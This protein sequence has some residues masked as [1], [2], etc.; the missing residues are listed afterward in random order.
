MS[1]WS[2]PDDDSTRSA[3]VLEILSDAWPLLRETRVPSRAINHPAL[4]P[5]TAVGMLTF[6][7]RVTERMIRPTFEDVVV[8]TAAQDGG[9]ATMLHYL[10]QE[11][12]RREPLI[13]TYGGRRRAMPLLRYRSLAA[14]VP[15]SFLLTAAGPHAYYHRFTTDWHLDLE[16]ILA[17]NGALAPLALE[18]LSYASGIRLPSPGTRLSQAQHLTGRLV[19]IYA[20]YL[21]YAALHG[22]MPET[23]KARALS[24]LVTADCLVDMA[25]ESPPLAALLESLRPSPAGSTAGE[26]NRDAS[27]V[28]Q[29]QPERCVVGTAK[30]SPAKTH[31]AA[32][33]EVQRPGTK[34]DDA[35]G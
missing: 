35:P 11:M 6:S 9:E 23:A 5:L 29:T 3:V 12:G 34:S 26:P 33:Q 30:K 14:G 25:A 7:L 22:M 13:V 32:T 17:G 16:D 4:Y 10:S 1:S 28:D 20:I 15:L 2:G 19:T 8:L 21:Q 27:G 31:R 18:D 24:E